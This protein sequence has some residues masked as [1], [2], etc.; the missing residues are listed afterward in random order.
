[1]F[2]EHIQMADEIH[3]VLAD[4]HPLVRQALREA[5]AREA[6]LRVVGEAGD[7]KAAI[8][9]VEALKPQVA[10]LDI[11]MPL[12]DGIG[13]AR[14]L[15]EKRIPV[16]I[17]FLTV[18]REGDLLE[19]ATSLGAK[20]YVL[21]DSAVADV[22]SAIRSV[23]RGIH[24]V[25]PAMAGHLIQARQR[26]A[27]LVEDQPG[28]KDLTPAERRV[29]KLVSEY[30]TTKQIADELCVSARTVEAHRAH[31]GTKLGLHGS[32]ALVKFAIQ[33]ASEL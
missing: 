13:V 30:K 5:I 19:E 4:D 32:L 26:A 9:R 1:M 11:D 3:I 12:L 20:G 16:E 17:V 33:H 24:Y 8:D 31:I 10:V 28:L 6:G 22:V 27:A 29:L 15:R 14:A 25:S 7:G 21:K 18:H 23:A 2:L